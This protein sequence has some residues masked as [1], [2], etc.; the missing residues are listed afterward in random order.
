MASLDEVLRGFSYDK[1][2]ERQVSAQESK[3]KLQ[4]HTEGEDALAR[5]HA[6]QQQQSSMDSQSSRMA[7]GQPANAPVV[8]KSAP[9]EDNTITGWGKS[10][11]RGVQDIFGGLFPQKEDNVAPPT[12]V[13]TQGESTQNPLAEGYSQTAQPPAQVSNSPL[14]GGG[15]G[16]PQQ[17]PQEGSIL[18]R[19][20]QGAVAAPEAL[21][22]ISQAADETGTRL[23]GVKQQ[24]Q[25]ALNA[26]LMG[27]PQGEKV[28]KQLQAQEEYLS[29]G[30]EKLLKDQ[31]TAKTDKID[32]MGNLASGA[33][34]SYERNPEKAKLEY[35]GLYNGLIDDFKRTFLLTHKD[36]ASNIPPED[37]QK[38]AEDQATS[39]GFPKELNDFTVGSLQLAISHSRT[40]KEQLSAQYAAQKANTASEKIASALIIS[41][42]SNASKE[43]VADKV[44][45]T[46]VA[47]TGMTVA[48]ANSRNDKTN[49]RIVNTQLQKSAND[50]AKQETEAE[51]LIAHAEVR[52]TDLIKVMNSAT[53]VEVRDTARK[54]L[55]DI[56]PRIEKQRSDLDAIKLEN[57][58]SNFKSGVTPSK[59]ETHTTK[60]GTVHQRPA[61]MSDDIWNKY[62]ATQ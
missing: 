29:K 61:G 19:A 57:K 1:V 12:D 37:L 11:A 41:Q 15:Q 16:Q 51:K 32:F 52:R 56:T 10:I 35:S 22:K 2:L 26:G 50:S 62:K 4:A 13:S 47:T 28:F 43:R 17:Q 44:A 20:S 30:H 31:L 7:A 48:G 59:V 40:A 5:Y 54:A 58:K 33:Y 9:S 8:N 42:N 25:H 53:N 27:T 23:T 18:S 38:V 3:D 49:S 45:A 34:F 60:N 14:G 36:I 21:N 6:M 39:F 46:K 24:I 55:N